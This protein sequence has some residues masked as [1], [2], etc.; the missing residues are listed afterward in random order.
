MWTKCFEEQ[1]SNSTN[2]KR[3]CVVTEPLY[4]HLTE[5]RTRC[6]LGIKPQLGSYSFLILMELEAASKRLRTASWIKQIPFREVSESLCNF[7]FV[8]H[9]I[10]HPIPCGEYDIST[11]KTKLKLS[12]VAK[13]Q[14]TQ[15]AGHDVPVN[16][17]VFPLML[18]ACSVDTPSIDPICLHRI[19]RRVASRVLC[20]LGLK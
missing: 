16:S 17:N 4:L 15:D 3:E 20:G 7:V 19:A 8:S 13:A 12:D 5:C 9:F 6:L 14:S 2:G 1:K 11:P 18:L 10:L